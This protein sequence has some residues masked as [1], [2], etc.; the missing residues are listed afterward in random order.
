[1]YPT[2]DIYKGIHSSFI[3]RRMGTLG[4]LHIMKS[5]TA[6]KTDPL[7]IHT[8]TWM[9][10]TDI[11]LRKRLQTQ[12]YMCGVTPFI[13]HSKQEKL[14]DGDGGQNVYL[15]G[16]LTGRGNQGYYGSRRA[17]NLDLGSGYAGVYSTCYGVNRIPLKFTRWSPDPHMTGWEKGSLWR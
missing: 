15:W 6:I 14:I 4:Q 12:K 11:V 17:V 1:M 13:G 9:N 5:Y 16:W 3:N 10:L 8:A 7:W 2:K